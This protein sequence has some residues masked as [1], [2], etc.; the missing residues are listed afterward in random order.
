MISKII[1]ILILSLSLF[2]A[3]SQ[4]Y[5][6]EVFPEL[7]SII[8][9]TYGESTDYQ[10][11]TQNLLFDFYEP[12]ND[13]ELKRPL[14]IYIHGGGF[15]SGSRSYPSV[16]KLCR[17]MASKGYA[18]ANID[19][20]LDPN[21]SLYNST[22][23]RRAMTDAMQDAKQ[24]IRYF[25]NLAS[26]YK[27]DTTKVCIGGES[28]GAITAM[29]ASYIDKQTEMNTY[30]M[31][32]PNNV[33]GS[34]AN[35]NIGNGVNA[36]LCL[37]GWILDTNAIETPNDSPILW[38][39]GSYDTFIPINLSFDIVLRA[40]NIGL[41]IQTKVFNGGI[42]CPWYYGN[43]N[44]ETYLDSTISEITTFLYPLASFVSS[45]EN[46]STINID[47]YPNPSNGS[48]NINLTNSAKTVELS[49]YSSLGVIIKKQTYLS[50]AKID[51]KI[52]NKG[53]YFIRLR[54]D[55]EYIVKKVIVN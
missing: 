10:G 53:L 51:F 21:F 3:N 49:I 37:C 9:G 42:H 22:T 5:L 26:T 54:I 19:Y 15:T 27:L 38:I 7:D 25:K 11:S 33:I 20:R 46:V 28:A 34:I 1:L 4:R 17:I 41:P 16:K 14:F 8:G 31:A 29:M 6:T 44:W 43:P 50:I 23:D 47:L 40:S 45:T 30:P 52:L 2:Q 24:A 12:K 35:S 36:T 18:V 48:F 32:V 39:H 13:T 55:G